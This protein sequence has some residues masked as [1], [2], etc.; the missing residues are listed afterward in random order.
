MPVKTSRK[1]ATDKKAKTKKS[2]S[3]NQASSSRVASAARQKN[4]NAKPVTSEAVLSRKNNTSVVQSYVPVAN[5]KY[6]SQRQLGYFKRVFESA[7]DNILNNT[8]RL[9]DTMRDEPNSIPD[10]NDRASKESEFTVELRERDRERRLLEKI[11]ESLKR[12][13][14]KKF[15]YCEECG[16]PIGIDRLLARPV[17]TLC[18]ECKNLQE[19][20]EKSGSILL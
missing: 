10:D 16:D 13:R 5:E 8:E 14:D 6:M 12:I 17:A 15:G 9:M 7:R 19:E 4:A 20:Y 2:E 1:K 3:A 11:D 18:I